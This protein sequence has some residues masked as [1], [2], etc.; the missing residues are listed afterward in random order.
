MKY[1]L[2]S[3]MCRAWEIRRGTRYTFVTALKLAWAEAKG[4]RVYT[5]NLENARACITAYLVK[6][7]KALSD[8]HQQ[9]K[10]DILRR[11]FWLPWTLPGWP[12]WTVRRW[13]CASTRSETH[14]QKGAFV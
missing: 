3:I 10:H 5:F 1:N 9:H 8:I 13:A 14:K 7:G 12:C 4:E 11:P 2:R 6:L